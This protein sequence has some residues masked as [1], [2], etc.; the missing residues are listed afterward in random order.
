VVYPAFC[1]HSHMPFA[2]LPIDLSVSH[3]L[4]TYHPAWMVWL[5]KGVSFITAPEILVGIFLLVVLYLYRQKKYLTATKIALLVAGNIL[6]P[7]L[8]FIFQRPRPSPALV[9]V[10]MHEVDFGFPSG[11]AL[12]VIIFAAAILVLIK[13]KNWLAYALATICIL[14]VG[15][16]RVFLGVHWVTDVLFGYFISLLWIT[17][18]III[19]W[20]QLNRFFGSKNPNT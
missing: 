2:P 19:F 10:F 14:A 18:C 15:Y 6:T 7:F 17:V 13:R 4:Q 11:H 16:A 20:P 8:K 3:A 12:G 1:Y 9:H 5:A